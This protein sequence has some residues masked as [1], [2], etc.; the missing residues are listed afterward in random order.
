MLD[1]VFLHAS[2]TGSGA[3]GDSIAIQVVQ[4]TLNQ[5]SVQ[6]SYNVP[7]VSTFDLDG[8]PVEIDV[9]GVTAGE[10][11]VL[12]SGALDCYTLDGTPDLP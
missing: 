7:K 3:P 6:V 5:Q 9:V 11:F 1:I 2:E 10:Q 8:G 12:V 4:R